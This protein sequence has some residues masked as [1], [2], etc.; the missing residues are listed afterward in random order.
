[1]WR[2]SILAIATLVLASGG[3]SGAED[4]PGARPG[5]SVKTPALSSFV[6]F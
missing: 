6:L 3:P 2:S 5:E 4:A 1:M